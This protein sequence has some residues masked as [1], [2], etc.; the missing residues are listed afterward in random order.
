MRRQRAW[1]S[2]RK[3][4]CLD[5]GSNDC[6]GSLGRARLGE[7]FGD[8]RVPAILATACCGAGCRLARRYRWSR[9]SDDLEQ[10]AEELEAHFGPAGPIQPATRFLEAIIQERDYA[11][12]WR[13]MDPDFRRRRAEQ[14]VEANARHP[15]LADRDL[16]EL[17]KG[18]GVIA[19]QSDLW[20]AFADVELSTF[21]NAWSHVDLET[22]LR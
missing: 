15:T 3:P 20:P 14:W 4:L 5:L 6:F 10:T 7:R 1:N 19:S 13:L 2:Q 21:R 11:A 12:A 8:G 9:M 22:A 16:D 18:L 17:I